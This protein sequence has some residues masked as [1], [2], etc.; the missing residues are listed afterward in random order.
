M[1][2][3]ETLDYNAAIDI[4]EAPLPPGEVIH[5]DGGSAAMEAVFVK[6]TVAARL[7]AVGDALDVEEQSVRRLAAGCC[8]SSRRAA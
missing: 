3:D 5:T 2:L 4:R 7:V 1:N 6:C 8:M